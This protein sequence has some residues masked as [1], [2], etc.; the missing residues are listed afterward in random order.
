MVVKIYPTQAQFFSESCQ[1]LS[2]NTAEQHSG[3]TIAL[4]DHGNWF[5][6]FNMILS[7]MVTSRL[8]KLC[9]FFCMANLFIYSV[10]KIKYFVKY[11]K[12]ASLYNSLFYTMSIETFDF[13][14]SV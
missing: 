11:I 6:S 13:L 7:V 3:F 12:N 8:K 14:S 4:F 2:L 1:K 5:R 10:K 9:R